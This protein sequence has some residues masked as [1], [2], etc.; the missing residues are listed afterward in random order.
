MMDS[1][2][3]IED[4]VEKIINGD[5]F[6]VQ[7]FDSAY[8]MQSVAIRKNTCY[9]VCAV[10]FNEKNDVLMMQEA[11]PSCYQQWYLPA[12]RME[13]NESIVEGMRREVREESGLDCEPI[14]LLLVQENGPQWIRFTFLAQVSGGSMKTTAEADEESLQAMWWDRVSSLP[15][16]ARDILPLIEAG[17]RYKE[18]TCFPPTLPVDTP[19]HVLCQRLI[20]TFTDTNRDLWLLLGTGKDLHLPVTVSG[21][22]PS[23]RSC[24]LAFAVRRLMKEC[25]PLSQ[26][27]VKTQGIFGLQHHGKDPGKTDGIC[28]NTLI[29]VEYK[30]EA[31][32]VV[33][34]EAPPALESEKFRWYKVDDPGLKAKV[35]QR[36]V[37]R[38]VIPFHSLF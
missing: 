29:S 33:H 34:T 31:V 27:S 12:G 15:L 37:S 38:S 6:A 24:Y 11:K 4:R 21:V 9:I 20:V 10:I 19:S 13:E 35:E 14:T 18:M 25:M 36:L 5:G 16:R 2:V 23:E 1:S 3:T 32:A 17:L 7:E 28:F 26:V 30:L 8:E 22:G